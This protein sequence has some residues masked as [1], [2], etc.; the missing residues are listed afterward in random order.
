MTKSD[1]INAVH[2]AAAEKSI[3]VTKKATGELIDLVFD[4][5]S[6]AVVAEERFSYPS[7][8]TFSVKKRKERE[9]RNPRTKEAITIPASNTI[10]FKPA[11]ALK[12]SVNPKKAEKAEKPA[13]KGAKKAKK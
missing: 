10:S 6:K 12:D 11:P 9:G 13:A 8:G 7:F 4:E 1:L 3:E 5:V 2:A